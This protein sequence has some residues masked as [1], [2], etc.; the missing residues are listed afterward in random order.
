MPNGKNIFDLSQ[1]KMHLN[2]YISKI[3]DTLTSPADIEAY[4]D[5]T[6]AISELNELT[7]NYYTLLPDDTYP[8]MTEEGKKEFLETYERVMKEY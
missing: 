4:A 2:E 1:I 8:I 5:F 7:N 6:A 3:K